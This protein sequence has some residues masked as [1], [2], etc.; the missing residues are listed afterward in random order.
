MGVG[1]FRGRGNEVVRGVKINGGEIVV[2]CSCGGGI[3]RG[4]KECAGFFVS[5]D[6]NSISYF[7]TASSSPLMVLRNR[8]VSVERYLWSRFLAASSPE[9]SSSNLFVMAVA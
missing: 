6:D 9:I 1:V 7:L 2:A 8:P 3:M 4:V 5:R